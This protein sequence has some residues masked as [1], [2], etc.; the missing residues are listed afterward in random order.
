MCHRSWH[1]LRSRVL[2]PDDDVCRGPSLFGAGVTLLPAGKKWGAA[3]VLLLIATWLATVAVKKRGLTG[4]LIHGPFL[5]SFFAGALMTKVRDPGGYPLDAS[6]E[7]P[8]SP[9]GQ[10]IGPPPGDLR[11][12][13]PASSSRTMIGRYKQ[14]W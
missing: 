8:R 12:R 11:L 13:E 9:H 1:S 5:S 10:A 14:I 3:E 2:S 7:S 6:R 4:L